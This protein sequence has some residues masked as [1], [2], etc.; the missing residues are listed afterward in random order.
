MKKNIFTYLLIIV[1]LISFML[2][3]CIS[4]SEKLSEL[5]KNQKQMQKEMT[6]IEQE[7]KEAKQRAE[8]YEKLIDKYKNLLEQKEQELNQLQATYVK[9]NNKDEALQAKKV[10]QEK[11]IK[12][13][14]DSVHLQKRLKRYTKKA[15]I[16]K[17]KSQQLDE[18]AK[19]TQERVEK[20]TQ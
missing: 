7:A 16:Y 19:Q 14:Q 12:S 20:T 4:K 5:E 18:K 2:A 8:K 9:L 17:E 6:T 11:L 10:I 15:N 13:A 1:A 3:G